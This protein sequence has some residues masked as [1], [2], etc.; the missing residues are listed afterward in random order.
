MTGPGVNEATTVG[1]R[2]RARREALLRAAEELFV[3]K[4]FEKTTLS[5]II[6]RAGG[7]RATLY[8]HFGDKQGLFR[9]MMED[10]SARIL[11]GLSAIEADDLTRPETALTGFALHFARILVEDRTVSIIRI[12]VAEGR[13]VPDIVESF[14]RIGPDQGKAKVAAFMTRLVDAGVLRLEN[15][16][17][18]ARAFLGMVTGD[19]LLRRLIAPD[20]PVPMDEVEVYIRQAVG[21]FLSGAGT[22]ERPL[23]PIVANGA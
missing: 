6:S 2:G 16:S 8:E 9:A 15:P 20:Q 18:A 1:P 13:R 3:E 11:G 12:L 14:F 19:L 17:T 10:N 23:A 4:G 7:S 22:A 5:D 21:L